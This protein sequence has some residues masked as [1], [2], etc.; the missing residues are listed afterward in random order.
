ML[1]G[2]RQPQGK[3]YMARRLSTL[4]IFIGTLQAVVTTRASAMALPG[5]FSGNARTLETSF[6]IAGA[7]VG[8]RS[9]A[10]ESCGCRGTH[11]VTRTDTVSSIAIGTGGNILTAIS[12]AATAFGDKS[13]G[14]ATV[15]QTVEVSKLNLLG[16]LITADSLKAAA[17]IGATANTLTDSTAGTSI[18]NLVV[19]GIPVAADV[20]ENTTLALPGIGSV[21]VKAV[22]E[23][24]NKT[25]GY[26]TVDLLV[27]NVDHANSLGLPVGGKLVVGKAEAGYTRTVPAAA[28]KG[29]ASIVGIKGDAGGL[30]NEHAGAGASVGL[31]GCS[32]TD[33]ETLRK[34][35]T[36]VTVAGLLSVATA[37]TTAFGG[38]VGQA[39]VARTSST[40][41]DV[42]LLGGVITASA[43]TA[44][45]QESRTG[46]ID[47]PSFDGSSFVG[48]AIAGLPV[49][50]QTPANTKLTL[51]GIGY[52]I[53]NEQLQAD[54]TTVVA[55]GL[56]I[57]VSDINLLGL[58]VGAQITLAHAT[59]GAT[60]P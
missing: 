18:V 55:N 52:V 53:V 29:F 2:N 38:P 8:L 32:G 46:T 43:L 3:F 24:A 28:L 31:P 17:S 30:L 37:K 27:I 40:L 19:A 36:D 15:K 50:A 16:G 7:A 11:G 56:H 23:H 49:S 60:K 12:S 54:K 22:T 33:G 35:V 42:S 1:A 5:E 47:T 20:A 21:T 4:A 14:A 9:G 44:V 57:V 6:V 34:S 45:A 25:Q 51:P 59:A 10:A 48:L 39:S 58:P 26:V 13:A 41:S